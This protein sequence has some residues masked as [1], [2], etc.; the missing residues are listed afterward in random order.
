M[1]H[2]FPQIFSYIGTRSKAAAFYNLDVELRVINSEK[3]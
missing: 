2:I 1:K 3:R